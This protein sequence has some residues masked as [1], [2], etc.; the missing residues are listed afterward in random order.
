MIESAESRV[1]LKRCAITSITTFGYAG[2]LCERPGMAA[3]SALPNVR[4][5]AAK[6]AS[7][8]AQI[9]RR[10]PPDF[11]LASPNESR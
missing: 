1:A 7:P 9:S 11:Y 10:Q 4:L 5:F 8:R 2:P 3:I 6:D